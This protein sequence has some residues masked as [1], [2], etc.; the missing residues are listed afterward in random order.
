MRNR[1]RRLLPAALTIALCICSPLDTASA[2]I[3]SL[4]EAEAQD[5][6]GLSD[7][8]AD[9]PRVRIGANDS[10]ATYKF[11]LK[12]YEILLGQSP[13]DIAFFSDGDSFTAGKERIERT[14]RDAATM[15]FEDTHISE[16]FDFI[17]QTY[18]VKVILD[19]RVI[20]PPKSEEEA[21]ETVPPDTEYV[22][23]GIVEYSKLHNLSLR[24]AFEAFLRPLGLDF[25]VQAGFIWISTP[26]K[27]ASE[28]FGFF[29]RPS[30][31][32]TL[33]R[34]GAY[35][36]HDKETV[37]LGKPEL[38]WSG[39]PEPSDPDIHLLAHPTMLLP[40]GLEGIVTV[41]DDTPI[42]YFEPAG[43]KGDKTFELKTLDVPA[44][45]KTS[46][47]ITSL[48]SVHEASVQLSLDISLVGA[49]LPLDGVSLNVGKPIVTH[50]PHSD[51]YH[52]T[53][54]C[55]ASLIGST[56][57]NSALLVFVKVSRRDQ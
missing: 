50:T 42:Q 27:I 22:T 37:L 31:V 39:K 44:G 57:S 30:S 43:S 20:R 41:S 51:V 19:N 1:L 26:E 21:G 53:L 23:D 54:G 10:K 5:A 6:P 33:R 48:K 2:Q 46:V 35:V 18:E 52:L 29:Y 34:E 3:S 40:E 4:F 17:S 47:I 15:L 7:R 8:A 55:W 28:S 32:F 36:F 13:G 11:E 38:R 12:L 16:I 24:Q 45:F 14:L 9:V 25:S 49:R 56:D